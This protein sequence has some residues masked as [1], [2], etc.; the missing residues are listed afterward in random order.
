MAYRNGNYIA[1]D[2]LGETD[3]TKSDFRYYASIQAWAKGKGH[4]FKYVDS[5]D[6]TLAVRD[7]S[8][9]ATLEARIRERLAASKN[10]VIILSDDTRQTGSMLSY[11]IEKAVDTYELPLICAYTDLNQMLSPSA[12]SHRWPLALKDRIEN[13]SARAIH[14]PFKKLALLHA[15]TYTVHSHSLE[16]G[17]HYYSLETHLKFGCVN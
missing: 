12:W 7:T 17:L 11:E 5:H 8:L 13:G 6:K 2:G 9:K 16:T 10:I 1:F 4:D 3:P 15:L 14:I